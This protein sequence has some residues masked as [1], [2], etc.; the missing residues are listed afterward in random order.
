MKQ[1]KYFNKKVK[2]IRSIHINS[3]E[4]I[5]IA[6]YGQDSDMF[7]L[8]AKFKL[9]VNDVIHCGGDYGSCEKWGEWIYTDSQNCI[10]SFCRAYSFN[11][12]AIHEAEKFFTELKKIKI[13]VILF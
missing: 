11:S 13:E 10:E 2:T 1:N 6:I 12:F 9:K 8:L 5:V 4:S 3:L 7:V